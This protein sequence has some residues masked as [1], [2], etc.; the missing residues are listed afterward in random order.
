[1]NPK[2]HHQTPAPTNHPILGLI[3]GL[4]LV[5]ILATSAMGNPMQVDDQTK[6]KATRPISSD[7]RQAMEKDIE[8]GPSQELDPKI[9]GSRITE[10]PA[11]TIP[12]EVILP[13]PP[14]HRIA[15]ERA[16]TRL[17]E[18]EWKTA[19]QSVRNGLAYLTATQ[20]KRGAWFEGKEV[21]PT[22]Q[23]PKEAAAATAVTALGLKAFAQAP[24]LAPDPMV[25]EKALDFL[26]M[27]IEQDGLDGLNEGGLGNYVTSALVMGLAAVGTDTGTLMSGVE[28]LQQ[29]QWDAEDGLDPRQD[30]YGGAGYGNRGR[31]DLSNTQMML[32]ALYD[33]GVSPD[34]PSVQRALVFLTRTQNLKETN[35]APWAQ[36]GNNDGGFIYTP[37]NNGESMASQAAGEGRY[38]ESMPAGEPRSLRSYGSMTYA[39]F[40][41]LLYAGLDANDPR[42]E[43][44]L[45]WARTH[46]TFEENPGVGQQGYYYYL[47]A[48]ARALRASGLTMIKDDQ[49]VEHDWR[50]ELIAALAD[51]QRADGSWRNPVDRWEEGRPDLATIY[52]LLAIEEALKPTLEVE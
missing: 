43:A 37:A 27:K 44:A 5:G 4:L 46:W 35:P 41:S 14:I 33:A 52:A 25:A 13:T 40:K 21:I 28:W 9:D 34:E 42:V 32:D 23:P 50:S 11:P 45:N 30:W 18:A 12:R 20:S 22:D 15:T 8:A 39:G 16:R 17:T 48:L 38:G 19:E 3:P 2:S 51:R 29:T 10:L 36:A 24:E 31:P 7:T 26:R 47:H 1:M 49:G 6:G